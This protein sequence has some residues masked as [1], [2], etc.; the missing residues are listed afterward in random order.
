MQSKEQQRYPAIVIR[1]FSGQ[2]DAAEFTQITQKLGVPGIR[3]RSIQV[4]QQGRNFMMRA[5]LQEEEPLRQIIDR[6]GYP[7]DWEKVLK[8]E[9]EGKERRRQQERKEAAQRREKGEGWS[10]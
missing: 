1:G 7:K 3:A 5:L 6:D 2:P 4:K 10:S 9:S 8:E